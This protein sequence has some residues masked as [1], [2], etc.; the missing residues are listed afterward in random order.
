MAMPILVLIDVEH[1][2]CWKLAMPAAREEARRRGAELHLLSVLPDFG[3][4]LVAQYFPADYGERMRNDALGA[5][6]KLGE[7]VIGDVVKWTPHVA[8]G[9]I[10]R[11]ILDT[12][13]RL[14]TGLIVMA[15]HSPGEHSFLTGSHADHV[16][17][18][19]ECSVYVLR[20]GTA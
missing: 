7:E 12:A 11:T 14:H 18:R 13:E 6:N 17:A 3:M 1:D 8:Q 10:V 5:L 19:A 20:N 16:V 9:E 15:A 4:S 2:T